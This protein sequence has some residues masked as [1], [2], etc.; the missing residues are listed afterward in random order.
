MTKAIEQVLGAKNLVGLIQGVLGGVPDD[1]LPPGFWAGG[2]NVTQTDGNT[3][4]YFKVDGTRQ[5][6][7]LVHY[8]APSVKR[9]LAGVTEVPVKLLHT[10]EHQHHTPATMMNLMAED[11]EAKQRMG[12]Q[13]V[14]RQVGNFGRLFANLRVSMV[15]SILNFGAIYFDGDGNLLPTS[16][17]AV[18]T[19]DFQVPAN[20]KNQ[21]NSIIA[22]SWATAGTDIPLH[23]SQIRKTAR[24]TTGYPIR[25]AFYGENIPTYFAAN[26]YVSNLLFNSP[27][28]TEDL[29]RGDVPDELMKLKWLPLSEAFFVDAAGTAQEWT[30]VDRVV[31]TPEPS[32]EWWEWLEGTYP[33]PQ[34]LQITSDASSALSGLS[35]VAGGFS[36]AELTTDPPGIKHLAGDTVLPLLKVPGAVFI[37]D[38][39]P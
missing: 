30:N 12:Q 6:A 21:L 16:S 9:A 35:P 26:D 34:N 14:A 15:Y 28:L 8:G 17:G 27:K 32:P 3:A 22:A 11:S 37:A 20:N 10:F 39:T 33:V 29:A 7:R 2:G 1:L 25:Y 23:V 31:F 4:T 24:K 38:V 18:V 19:V 13:T 36:Y 5:T